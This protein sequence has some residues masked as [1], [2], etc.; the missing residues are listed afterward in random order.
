MKQ[1]LA[2]REESLRLSSARLEITDIINQRKDNSHLV[3]EPEKGVSGNCEEGTQPLPRRLFQSSTQDLH[4]GPSNA[5]EP[6]EY[7]KEN[8]GLNTGW[9]P[10]EDPQENIEGNEDRA[11][12]LPQIVKMFNNS[13]SESHDDNETETDIDQTQVKSRPP[14]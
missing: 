12:P 14:C 5:L 6:S 10:L 13:G 11:S 1:S 2:A 8:P 3:S 9:V 4:A 7:M